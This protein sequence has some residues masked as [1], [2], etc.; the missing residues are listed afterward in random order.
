MNDPYTN[1]PYAHASP[2]VLTL[3]SYGATRFTGPPPEIKWLVQHSIPLGVACLLVAMGGVGKSYLILLLCLLVTSQ[4]FE[5]PGTTDK[6]IHNLNTFTRPLLGGT[7]A[8]DGKAVFITAED[9]ESTIHRRLAVL[10]PQERRT[11]DLIVIALP[12]VGGPVPFFV[13]D[14][15]GVRATPEWHALREQL[16]AIPDLKLIAIDPLA[17]F[18]Q[19]T[20]TATRQ[21]RSS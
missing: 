9:D 18:C 8:E 11:D 20:W 12:N 10:D 4:R 21:H 14:R 1:D 19:V 7:V 15:D 17:A 2:R 13:S 3:A 5:N 16:L 6:Q